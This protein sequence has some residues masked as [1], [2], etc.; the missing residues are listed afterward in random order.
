[1]SDILVADTKAH[2]NLSKMAEATRNEAKIFQSLAEPLLDNQIQ[3]VYLI[4]T[5]SSDM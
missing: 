2:L 4:R 5:I 3:E 1:M